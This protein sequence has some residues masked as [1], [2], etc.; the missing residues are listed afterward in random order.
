MSPTASMLAYTILPPEPTIVGR[1][2]DALDLLNRLSTNDLRQLQR[3]ES[4]RTILVNEKGRM[5]DILTVA[6]E[7][8][9][10]R[11]YP[12]PGNLKNVITWLERFI[13]LEDA[14][15]EASA[16]AITRIRFLTIGIDLHEAERTQK[17]AISFD[18]K[19]L[20]NSLQNI[21]NALFH[22][23]P[24]QRQSAEAF[25]R[26]DSI[27][28]VE[29]VLDE[30]EAVALTAREYEQ[31]R[32]VA[33]LPEFPSEINEAFNPLEAGL[34]TLLSETKGCYIGQEVLARLKTYNKVQRSL[35]K[36]LVSKHIALST[37]LTDD[38]L[39]AV[40]Q[41]TSIAPNH[42]SDGWPALG[43]VRGS[44]ARVGS[45]IEAANDMEVRVNDIL[46]MDDQNA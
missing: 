17:N 1:G 18:W 35:C 4:K 46:T 30:R 39:P 43:Y 25:L 28:E 42:A 13:F 29:R 27:G 41:I 14:R 15:F 5:I 2:K 6:M 38:D 23:T 34:I 33:G 32:I 7:E 9:Q 36:L 26:P 11:I 37:S 44:H 12:S 8:D 10:L 24:G 20:Q 3:N 22:L 16:Q 21:S 19:E 45:H 31:Q 40:V